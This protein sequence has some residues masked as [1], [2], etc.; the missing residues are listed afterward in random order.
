LLCRFR[1]AYEPSYIALIPAQRDLVFTIVF[2]IQVST[3]K[4]LQFCKELP[5]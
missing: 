5:A 2:T 1:P 3:G 4:G